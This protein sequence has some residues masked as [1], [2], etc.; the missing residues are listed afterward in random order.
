MHTANFYANFAPDRRKCP[1]GSSI[2]RQ[3]GVKPLFLCEYGVPISW[4]WTM[5]RGWYHDIRTF[6]SAQVPW[7]FCLA[8][9]DAQFL[10]DPAF[11]VTELE[12]EC[13]RWEARQFRAGKC[14]TAGITRAMPSSRPI[15]NSATRSFQCI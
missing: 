5:Y 4:D 13:L 2:G 10:G 7:E 1:I 11:K 15:L 14:G 12:K 3:T 6:G 9:W 8:E